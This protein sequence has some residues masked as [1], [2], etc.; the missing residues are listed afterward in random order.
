MVAGDRESRRQLRGP[1]APVPVLLLLPARPDD[2]ADNT[3]GQLGCLR[4][5]RRGGSAARVHH[6]QPHGAAQPTRSTC[7]PRS[8]SSTTAGSPS[9]RPT[10]TNTRCSTTPRRSTSRRP[11]ARAPDPTAAL[12]RTPRR[13][14]RLQSAGSPAQV[15]DEVLAPAAR[16]FSPAATRTSPAGRASRPCRCAPRRARRLRQ[17][18]RRARAPWTVSRR[19]T[20]RPPGP[21]RRWGARKRRL[22]SARARP[23]RVTPPRARAPRRP[24]RRRPR[25]PGLTSVTPV[26]ARPPFFGAAERGACGPRRPRGRVEVGERA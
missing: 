5:G 8:P 13:R 3:R 22:A 7:T 26:P 17:P 12:G 18:A 24:G 11:G 21:A 1:A 19:A 10:S 9:A 6:P 16:A 23:T 15:V 14:P 20:G 25:A 4:G 2:G